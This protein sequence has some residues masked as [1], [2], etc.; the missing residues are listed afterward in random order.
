MQ[1]FKVIL[2]TS[3]KRIRSLWDYFYAGKSV[4]HMYTKY[5][6]VFAWTCLY[7]E[8]I[9]NEFATKTPSNNTTRATTATHSK[10]YAKR[11]CADLNCI[12]NELE[13]SDY[14]VTRQKKQIDAHIYVPKS[15]TFDVHIYKYV[16]EGQSFEH[17]KNM[18]KFMK[19]NRKML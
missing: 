11:S 8:Y 13:R 6:S 5:N 14:S 16:F 19:I 15:L 9:L 4:W 18:H 7:C 2:P 1:I 12:H 17:V 10:V 3:N